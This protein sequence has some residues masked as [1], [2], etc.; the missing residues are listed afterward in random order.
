MGGYVLEVYNSHHVALKLIF[1]GCLL[2]C[3]K[4]TWPQ[5]AFELQNNRKRQT[6]HFSLVRILIIVKLYINNHGPYN[7]VMG[8]GVGVFLITDPNL[9]DSLDI[10]NKRI[11]KI[12]GLGAA[13]TVEAAV[14]PSISVNISGIIAKS[15][16]AAILKKDLFGLSNYARIPIYCLIGYKFFA[17][18]PIKLNFLDSTLTA[19]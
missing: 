7:F 14:T 12:A 16:S 2:F 10:R 17:C 19:Y 18:F 6:V 15:V 8:T 3:T 11:I 4:N 5:V 1:I 9:S 13:E